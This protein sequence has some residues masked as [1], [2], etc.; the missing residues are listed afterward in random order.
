M[1]NFFNQ[2]VVV[3][4][5]QERNVGSIG[6]F[7]RHQQSWPPRDEY[8]RVVDMKYNKVH[9]LDDKRNFLMMRWIDNGEV[10]MLTTVHGDDGYETVH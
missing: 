9:L 3:E 8:K 2:L 4:A 1:D 5:V 10:D 6:T 7:R